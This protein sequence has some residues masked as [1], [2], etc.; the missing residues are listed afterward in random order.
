[1]KNFFTLLFLI[2][3]LSLYGQKEANI[4]HFG[5]NAGLDFNPGSPATSI[6]GSAMVTQEGCASIADKKGDL[7]FYTDGVSVWNK[8]HKVM[9]NGTGLNGSFSSAQSGVIIPKPVNDSI[10][11]I[12]TI[13]GHTH[14]GLGYYYSEVNVKLRSDSGEV[15][16]KNVALLED[17]AGTWKPECIGAA[18]HS[19]GRD[20]WVVLKDNYNDSF[21]SYLVSP[22]GVA[23]T[24]VKS[25]AGPSLGGGTFYMKISPD[26]KTMAVDYLMPNNV[27]LFDF[28]DKTGVVSN[29]R[30]LTASYTYSMAFSPNSKV[31]YTDGPSGG[32]IVQY[33]LDAGTHADVVASATTVYSGGGSLYAKQLGPD[34]KIYIC[35]YGTTEMHVIYNPDSLGSA[36]NYRDD[37]L[38]L[39]YGNCRIGLPTFIATYFLPINWEYVGDCLGD[40]TF[41]L[42][43][44]DTNA[45][46]SVRW[47]FDDPASGSMN[48]STRFEPWHIFT[49]KD[50]FNVCLI[51]YDTNGF[52]DTICQLV[53]IADDPVVYL[54][55][56]TILCLGTDWEIAPTFS[57]EPSW[58]WIDSTT[59]SSFT[60]TTDGLYW[61]QVTNRC[62]IDHDTVLVLYDDPLAPDL[63]NDTALCWGDVLNFDVTD[64][65]ADTYLWSDGKTTPTNSIDEPGVFFVE[66]TNACGPFTDTIEVTFDGPPDFQFTAPDTIVCIGD[67]ILL[68]ASYPGAEVTWPDNSHGLFFGVT[69]PGLYG[70]KLENYCGEDYDSI[71]VD[72][73]NCCAI[74]L[75]NAFTPN[76]DGLNDELDLIHPYC[77][78]SNYELKIFNRAGQIVFQSTNPEEGWNGM[79]NGKDLDMGVFV[80]TLTYTIVGDNYDG[81]IE[82]GVPHFETGNITLLR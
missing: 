47:H 15:T 9:Y 55:E 5:E 35:K 27:Y 12:F 6:G 34:G 21:H 26:G 49:K 37:S 50:T 72:F 20:I 58:M 82:G 24:P 22:A 4:W 57:T 18:R 17:G 30:A 76:N 66:M 14:L 62:G 31:L 81:S 59:D 10:Y 71:Y 78:I 51:S 11:Y 32:K 48:T 53:D 43:S 52:I 77:A 45:L 67:E 75:P 64:P 79:W 56:D 39:S 74:G 61:V 60:I 65:E 80:Y 68:T 7:L 13:S 36:C 38:T 23:A 42:L 41:F 25:A 28:D 33:N 69:L 19:N 40:T 46:D 63:G 1:M 70:V 44:V 54:P 29:G 73:N 16:V 2:S 3:S 8:H